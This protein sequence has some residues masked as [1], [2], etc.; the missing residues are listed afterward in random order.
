MNITFFNV[1]GNSL[2][3]NLDMNNI[4]ISFGSACASGST[5]APLALLEMGMPDDEAKCT[6]RIS[7]GKFITKDDIDNLAD[8]I[9]KI[10]SRI[11]K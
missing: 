1:D 8:T 2:V 7:I 5:S 11:K 3:M 6:V 4:A 10:I 9:N